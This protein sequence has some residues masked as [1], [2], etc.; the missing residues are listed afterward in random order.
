MGVDFMKNIKDYYH[1][2]ENINYLKTTFGKD[3]WVLASGQDTLN[4]ASAGFWCAL[5]DMEYVDT[6]NSDC[7]W[8]NHRGAQV[9]QLEEYED[10]IMYTFRGNDYSHTENIVNY[11]EFYGIKPDYVELVDEFVLLNNMYYDVQS[12]IYYAVSDDGEC[13]EVAKITENTN[14]YIK[15]QYLVRYATIK[16]KALI[17]FFDIRTKTTGTLKENHLEAFN[18]EYRSET[19]I[20]NLWGDEMRPGN[21]VYSVLMGKKI[22]FPKPIEECGY[23]PFEKEK[24]FCDF[25]IGID[26][27]GDNIMHSCNPY[28]LANNFGGNPDAP[29]YLTPVY[30]KKDVL[31]KYYSQPDIYS[32]KDS[33]LA[34]GGLWSVS[35][36]N[37]HK[38]VV[39][40][41]LGDL[42]RDLP[43]KEQD[44]WKIYNIPSSEKISDVQFKRD[45]CC[46]FTSPEISDL[47][48]KAAFEKFQLEWKDKYKWY[49]FIPLRED[50]EYNFKNLHL[51]IHNTQAEFDSLIL[52]LV[53][54]IIDS[55][56]EKEVKRMITS[57]DKFNGS[58]SK[59]EQWFTESGQSNYDSHIKFLRNL[60]ELRSCGSGHRKGKGYSKISTEFGLNGNNY[61]DVFDDIL[62]QAIEFLKFLAV[63]FL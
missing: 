9:P 35:I 18:D 54:T 28:K 58:I 29:H 21:N 62:K 30:F 36:D 31:Q 63:T 13:E 52:S 24:E 37:H 20:F 46:L 19:L 27:Y 12:K 2:K 23:Y 51:P 25:I 43:E 53:K 33:I 47:K 16:Q 4:G 10:G 56:N 8:D 6:F 42:G 41:Y 32:V 22:I 7:A 26:E 59:L 5:G 38:D 49:L 3:V 60:Q 55:V 57:T 44:H 11:R 15:L 17:L 39:G 1:Q 34:C 50:D 61:S 48:F 40:V 45:F 14:I